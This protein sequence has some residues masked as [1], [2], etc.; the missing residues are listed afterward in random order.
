MRGG[1]LGG[2]SA[3]GAPPPN[4]A[5]SAPCALSSHVSR[6]Q[7]GARG[8]GGG[9]SEGGRQSTPARARNAV[10][11]SL[12]PLTSSTRWGAPSSSG[13]SRTARSAIARGGRGGWD[14]VLGGQGKKKKGGVRGAV[15]N[16]TP[17]PRP[18]RPPPSP[19]QQTK[20]RHHVS[21]PPRLRHRAPPR[22]AVRGGP[23]APRRA[24]HAQARGGRAAGGA[25]GQRGDGACGH[26]QLF[27]W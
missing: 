1:V 24:R 16:I 2:D 11:L 5:P 9:A 20:R 22:P 25:A 13:G 4:L 21:P 18:A 12:L 14:R 10:V 27:R 6:V 8:G 19:T 23:L 26:H 3:G 17:F 15:K 7:A